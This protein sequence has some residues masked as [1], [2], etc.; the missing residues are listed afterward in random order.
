VTATALLTAWEG[1][2]RTGFNMLP[3]N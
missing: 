1:A 3:G 2:V